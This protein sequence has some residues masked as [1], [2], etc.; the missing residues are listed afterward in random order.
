MW[1][2]LFVPPQF[3]KGGG[4]RP[5]QCLSGLVL[6]LAHDYVVV[7]V[8]VVSLQTVAQTWMPILMNQLGEMWPGGVHE[9]LGLT[10][11]YLTPR[12]PLVLVEGA[13]LATETLQNGSPPP[14]EFFS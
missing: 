10:I 5:V 14:D 6:R 11:K 7:A 13:P 2:F 9:S 3:S 12:A 8:E 1:R 4:G